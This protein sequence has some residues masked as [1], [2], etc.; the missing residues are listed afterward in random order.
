MAVGR[1]ELITGEVRWAR[2][3]PALV[4][5]EQGGRRPVLVIGNELYLAT[6]TT[7]ALVVPLTTVDRGW[8]NHVEV[9]LD[10]LPARSFAMTEQ[11]RVVSRERL[12]VSLGRV[13][14]ATVKDVRAW[15]IDYL[16]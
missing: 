15:V 13:S 3:D 4:G 8:D 16:V 12:G 14:A 11:V 7:L 10:S 5:R 1:V 2:P 6:V 9:E